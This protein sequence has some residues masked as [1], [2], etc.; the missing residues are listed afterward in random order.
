MFIN[1]FCQ[2]QH[3]ARIEHSVPA[4]GTLGDRIHK[5][6]KRRAV[7]LRYNMMPLAVVHIIAV[8]LSG[9]G[10]NVSIVTQPET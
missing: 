6:F 5:E 8:N 2:T 4:D 10:L 1:P 3:I 7:P 9:A